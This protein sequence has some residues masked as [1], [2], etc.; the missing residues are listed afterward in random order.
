VCE[1]A[2]AL[3]EGGYVYDS[4]IRRQGGQESGREDETTDVVHSKAGFY[5]IL[6]K[7]KVIFEN[8][9]VVDK[10]VDLIIRG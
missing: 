8:S 4:G 5:A 2:E 10:Y 3:C 7:M 9:G 1:G 6:G